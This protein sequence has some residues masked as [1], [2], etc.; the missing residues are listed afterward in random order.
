MSYSTDR[1]NEIETYV[2]HR[3][4]QLYFVQQHPAGMMM[5]SEETLQPITRR[6]NPKTTQGKAKA[7]PLS[8]LNQA[9]V[10]HAMLLSR[11][12]EPFGLKHHE[13]RSMFTVCSFLPESYYITDITE[14][15]EFLESQ[16][17]MSQIDDLAAAK[18]ALA[19]TP[20]E[21]SI[22]LLKV[23]YHVRRLFQPSQT[24]IEAI[25]SRGQFLRQVSKAIDFKPPLPFDTFNL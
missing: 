20:T 12:P 5:T 24:E 25:S 2:E 19:R 10:E 9:L 8:K 15:G 17:T 3:D 11:Y 7:T 4:G 13:K 18:A 6:K 14:A 23:P 22:Y 1:L 16:Q 21:A